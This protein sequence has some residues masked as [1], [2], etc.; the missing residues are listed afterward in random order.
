MDSVLRGQL[1]AQLPHT[2]IMNLKSLQPLGVLASVHLHVLCCTSALAVTDSESIPGPASSV[3]H[4]NLQTEGVQPS[5]VCQTSPK[6]KLN[7]IH[8][9]VVSHS[10][11]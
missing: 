7:L 3:G 8:L 6:I 11:L 5:S 9:C 4:C 10:G 2:F 1:F